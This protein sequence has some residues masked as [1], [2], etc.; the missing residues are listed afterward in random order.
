ANIPRRHPHLELTRHGP[1]P[2]LALQQVPF[3][4]P[5]LIPEDH[6]GGLDAQPRV[7]AQHRPRHALQRDSSTEDESAPRLEALDDLYLQIEV[8][9]YREDQSINGASSLR[10]IRRTR[11]GTTK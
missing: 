3:T 7:A 4:Q 8:Q 5:W 1:S 10:E 6:P 11:Q 9:L 2:C